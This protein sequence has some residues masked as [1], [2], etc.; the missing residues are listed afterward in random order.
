M[1]SVD[2]NY[3][4]EILKETAWS[5]AAAD[6]AAMLALVIQSGTVVHIACVQLRSDF[7]TQ[8][9][10]STGNLLQQHNYS[11]KVRLMREQDQNECACVEQEQQHRIEHS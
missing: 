6:S 3:E 11:V 10:N 7:K 8:P 4:A 9:L 5:E 2:R 1:F